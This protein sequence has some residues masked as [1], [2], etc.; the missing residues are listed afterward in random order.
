MPKLAIIIVATELP[1]YATV[2]RPTAKAV[3]FIIV[4]IA[5]TKAIIN[6]KLMLENKS[7]GII[8][9]IKFCSTILSPLKAITFV[10]RP[11][12]PFIIPLDIIFNTT[13]V[14]S[15]P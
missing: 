13:V 14:S 9:I 15:T 11:P 7:L 12:N 8:E 6:I 4:D 3:F 1:K 5:N 10:A 2:V